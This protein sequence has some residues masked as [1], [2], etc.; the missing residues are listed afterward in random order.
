MPLERG[1]YVNDDEHAVNSRIVP[2]EQAPIHGRL[3]RLKPINPAYHEQF[4]VQIIK[5][6]I[7]D[8]SFSAGVVIKNQHSCAEFLFKNNWCRT[9]FIPSRS[10]VELGSITR[11]WSRF[12]VVL[13]GSLAA[14][15]AMNTTP[16]RRVP[17]TNLFMLHILD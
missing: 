9:I 5:L 8:W 3:T 13:K 11:S 7:I 10:G 16:S 4:A 14:R 6:D 17:A 12:S 15:P 2:I 1:S